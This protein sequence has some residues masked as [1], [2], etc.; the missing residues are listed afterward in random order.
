MKLLLIFCL[1]S[2]VHSFLTPARLRQIAISRAVVSSLTETLAVN[3]FDI[4]AVIHEVACDCEQHPYLPLYVGGFVVFSYLYVVK[5]GDD[6]LTTVLF[7]SDFK[8]KI[9]AFLLICFLI[10]GK[11]IENAI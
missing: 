3:V 2:G 5:G 8:R 10:L 6:K 1:V 4:S 9:R 11:N 7:Y